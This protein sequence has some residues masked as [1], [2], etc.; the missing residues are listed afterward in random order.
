MSSIKFCVRFAIPFLS[1]IAI[2]IFFSGGNGPGGGFQAGVLLFT[3]LMIHSIILNHGKIFILNK[4]IDAMLSLGMLTYM[5]C[6]ASCLI[7]GGSMFEY[8]ILH[9]KIG[10]QIGI[11]ITEGSIMIVVFAGLTKVGSRLLQILPSH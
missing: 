10:Y 8:K 9:E 5:V 2:Y 1:F 11:S 3:L 7:L 6:G 4:A